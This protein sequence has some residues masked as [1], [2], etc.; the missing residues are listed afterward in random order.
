MDLRSRRSM[1]PSSQVG[2]ES[3]LPGRAEALTVRRIRELSRATAGNRP[4]SIPR[5]PGPR[6]PSP[7]AADRR[8]PPPGEFPVALRRTEIPRLATTPPRRV[9]GSVSDVYSG[10]LVASSGLLPC[11]E[12]CAAGPGISLDFGLVRTHGF[13]SQNTA[14]SGTAATADRKFGRTDTVPAPLAERV[15]DDAVFERMIGNDDETP[16]R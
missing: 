10:C 14:K 13:P 2:T 15:L 4:G 16:V 6:V 1:A 11:S 12:S 3:R 7:R 9:S 5:P 8:V